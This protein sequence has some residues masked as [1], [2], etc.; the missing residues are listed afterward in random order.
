MTARR[1]TGFL[2]A[3]VAGAGLGIVPSST[4]ITLLH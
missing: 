1:L 3:S 2:L 4:L